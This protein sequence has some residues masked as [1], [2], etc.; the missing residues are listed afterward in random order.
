MAARKTFTRK[1]VRDR[2]WPKVDVRGPDECWEWRGARLPHGYGVIGSGG[3]HGHNL[4]AHRV[5]YE[6]SIGPILDGMKVY[7][8]CDNPPCV[9]PGHLFLGTQ[10]DNIH[11]MISKG[12]QAP[13]SETRHVG[14]ASG[15]AVL[16]EDDVRVMRAAFVNGERICN[17]ARQY[18]VG[19]TAASDAVRG[20]TWRHVA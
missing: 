8:H 2:F 16:T 14:E 5:S 17:L 18:G 9:N 11:D 15:A 20:R 19:W 7:H 4:Y 13:V 3:K 1:P 12:R 6:L 10:R